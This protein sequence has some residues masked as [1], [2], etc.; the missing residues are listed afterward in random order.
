MT[1]P[2]DYAFAEELQWDD[3]LPVSRFRTPI[4]VFGGVFAVV[5]LGVGLRW[6]A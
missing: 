5:C 3:D 6:L 4:V 2:R 1:D